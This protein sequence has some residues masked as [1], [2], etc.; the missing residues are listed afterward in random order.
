MLGIVSMNR[1]VGFYTNDKVEA[2]VFMQE[3]N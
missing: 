2:R 1:T 3:R